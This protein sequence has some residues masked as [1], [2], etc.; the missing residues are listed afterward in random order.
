MRVILVALSDNRSWVALAVAVAVSRKGN[1]FINLPYLPCTGSRGPAGSQDDVTK[2]VHSRYRA[3][4]GDPIP[5]V[6]RIPNKYQSHNLSAVSAT[7]SERSQ[8]DNA[9]LDL[10]PAPHTHYLPG[11]SIGQPKEVQIISNAMMKAYVAMRGNWLGDEDGKDDPLFKWIQQRGESAKGSKP[12]NSNR[13]IARYVTLIV[14]LSAP[15]LK[16][17]RMYR[18]RQRLGLTLSLIRMLEMVDKALESA[19]RG[20]DSPRDCIFELQRPNYGHIKPPQNMDLST[21]EFTDSC[22]DFEWEE[23]PDDEEAGVR[24]GR[25]SPCTFL[26]WSKGCV[27]WNGDREEHKAPLEVRENL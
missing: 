6:P 25:I 10:I 5:Q 1:I 18:S 24:D 3:G 13:D 7:A 17:R 4:S 23:D 2:Q 26:Q 16:T 11:C 22:T 14:S 15:L 9:E 20:G 12:V 21:H 8:G 27:L 19:N